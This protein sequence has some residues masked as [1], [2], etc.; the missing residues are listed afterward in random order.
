MRHTTETICQNVDVSFH[1][2][3]T[4]A[5]RVIQTFKKKNVSS[6]VSRP[7]IPD[8]TFQKRAVLTKDM[9]N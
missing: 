3:S 7:V 4:P 9:K 5:K 2:N 8:K 1:V 6:L